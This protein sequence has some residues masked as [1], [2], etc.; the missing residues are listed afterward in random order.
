VDYVDV[1]SYLKIAPVRVTLLSPGTFNRYMEEKK[2]EGADL[3]HLKPSHVNPSRDIIER[4][5]RHSEAAARQ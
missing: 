5:F 1:E 2:K 3:A 4:L